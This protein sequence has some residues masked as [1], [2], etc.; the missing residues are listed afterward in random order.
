MLR[1]LS[2]IFQHLVYLIREDFLIPQLFL[3]HLVLWIVIVFLQMIE[4]TFILVDFSTYKDFLHV[5]RRLFFSSVCQI[6][7]IY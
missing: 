2:F 7:D 1:Y 5:F 3:F 6:E 4:Q